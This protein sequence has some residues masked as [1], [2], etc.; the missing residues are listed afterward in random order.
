[1]FCGDTWC[2]EARAAVSGWCVKIL[3][4]TVMRRL[5]LHSDYIVVISWDGDCGVETRLKCV[6]A[7]VTGY[8][9]RRAR[10]NNRDVPNDIF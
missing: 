8:P 2:A 7:I 5:W 4:E 6:K 3:R 9:R 10:R 1:M